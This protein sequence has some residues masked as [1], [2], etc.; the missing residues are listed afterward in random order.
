MLYASCQ[1][2][3]SLGFTQEAVY[4]MTFCFKYLY[5]VI[6]I[7]FSEIHLVRFL[8]SSHVYLVVHLDSL[9]HWQL[10]L[11]STVTE[12]FVA[13]SSKWYSYGIHLVNCF[14]SHAFELPLL[15]IF[16]QGAGWKIV[17]SFEGNFPN[18]I[19]QLP[20]DRHFDINNVKRVYFV[21]PLFSKFPYYRLSCI[22]FQ[23]FFES[24][25]DL[26]IL[27][28]VLDCVRSGWLSAISHIP[29]KGFKIL[30]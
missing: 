7:F 5:M 21:L 22:V 28:F 17:A 15:L 6:V 9:C 12:L 23:V 3:S 18:R 26:S 16:L 20:L 13:F 27:K 30:N 25:F 8:A 10:P 4:E 11:S 14:L 29:W 2:S 1:H 24:S 19:K